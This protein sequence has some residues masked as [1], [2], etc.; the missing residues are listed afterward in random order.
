MLGPRHRGRSASGCVRAG[1]AAARSVNSAQSMAPA[2]LA[3]P[4]ATGTWTMAQPARLPR[5]PPAAARSAASRSA[6]RKR[7]GDEQRARAA[8]ADHVERLGA[9]EPGADRDQRG[10]GGS[11]PRA[12]ST[13]WWRVGAPDRDPV[14]GGDA[15]GDERAGDLA[16]PLVQLAVAE[17][18]GRRARPAPPRRRTPAP[19]SRRPPGS[20]TLHRLDSTKQVLGRVS[21]RAAAIAGQTRVLPRAC[22]PPRPAGPAQGGTG[23]QFSPQDE[24]FRRRV[25]EWLAANV[26]RRSPSCAAPAAPAASTRRSPSGWPGTGGWPRRAGPASAGRPSTAGATRRWPAGDLPRGVRAQ[27]GARPGRGTWARNCSGRR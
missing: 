19:R 18:A 11:A 3:G 9:G 5:A 23:L 6:P 20:V 22:T 8:A 16:G 10:P 2:G 14:A 17:A 21:L 12:A 1:V 15:V 7:S 27:R 24:E 25:R 4:R 13:Q 26:H